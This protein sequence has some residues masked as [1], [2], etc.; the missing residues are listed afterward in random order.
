MRFRGCDAALSHA[1]SAALACALVLITHV[2]VANAAAPRY[3]RA[4]DARASTRVLDTP[5]VCPVIDDAYV[6]AFY[7]GFNSGE[8]RVGTHFVS[9]D[10]YPWSTVIKVDLSPLAG[11]YVGSAVLKLYVVWTEGDPAVC[12]FNVSSESCEWDEET[13][14][15]DT[16]YQC[17]EN[18]WSS[19]PIQQGPDCWEYDVT[20]RV[21]E[22]IAE[23]ESDVT[24]KLVSSWEPPPGTC[25]SARSR[26]AA[27]WVFHSKESSFGQRPQVEAVPGATVASA[28][29]EQAESPQ[30]LHTVCAVNTDVVWAGGE[31][32]TIRLTT[33]GGSTWQDRSIPTSRSVVSLHAF[34]ALSCVAAAVVPDPS[35]VWRTS[36]GGQ[37]WTLVASPSTYVNGVHFFNAQNGWLVADPYGGT[38]T[39]LLTS[40]GGQ[41]WHPAPTAPP[42]GAGIWGLERSFTWVG[43]SIGMFG[44]TSGSIWRTSNGGGAWQSIATGAGDVYAVAVNA[45]G[46]GFAGGGYG[47]PMGALARTDDY[48]ASWHLVQSPTSGSPFYDL[49]WVENTN[50]IWAASQSCGAGHTQRSTNAGSCWVVY[51]LGS[52]SSF[53]WDLDLADANTGWAA[54]HDWNDGHGRIWKF[55]SGGAQENPALPDSGDAGGWAFDGAESGTWFDPPVVP[56]YRYTMTSA[57]LFEAILDFPTGFDAPF[58]VTVGDTP[59]GEFS[60]GDVVSLGGVSE[61]TITGIQPM[62]DAEDAA[63]F[64]IKLAFDTP[65]ADFVMAPLEAADIGPADMTPML[66]TRAAPNPSRH[67][68]ALRF[69]T[70]APGPVKL[71]VFDTAG[72]LVRTVLEAFSER[73]TH[74]Y[75][76]DGRGRERCG[77]CARRVLLRHHRRGRDGFG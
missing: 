10:P 26:D 42:A 25:I 15:W 54:G 24:F 2:G 77:R 38:F 29:Q 9:D 66:R 47:D 32:G 34:D 37:S 48:G 22:A 46:I 73:G 21:N 43:Q 57:S 39:I 27:S 17:L 74:N 70:T 69:A 67:G 71:E 63:A 36:N 4:S 59:L 64:P 8:L 7:G 20:C 76:W 31:M 11:Q 60:P 40:D 61:F 5:V 12:F 53:V 44:T 23:G 72:R 35:E 65:T 49:L 13:I 41:T 68:V 16:E 18:S 58:T 3:G 6:D 52:Q 45:D 19:Y 33:D 50:N 28:W 1:L 30:S 51:A 55:T 56:G 62:V 75:V 14:A